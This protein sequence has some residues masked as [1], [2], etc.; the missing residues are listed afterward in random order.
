MFSQS[1]IIGIGGI[2]RAGK[3]FLAKKMADFYTKSGV[4][5]NILDQDNFVFP[6]EEI[7]RING[8]IDWECPESI[9]FPLLYNLIHKSRKSNDVTIVEGILVFW[10]INLINLFDYKI[11]MTLPKDEFIKRKREDLRW[12]KEPEWY[13][14]YIWKMHQ[15]FGQLP[16]AN[17][18]DQI[19]DGR[20]VFNFDEILKTLNHSLITV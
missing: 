4:K 3:S 20:E 1:K 12:G 18:A 19:L 6:K 13:I 10:N 8:H 16:K 9:D 2:S 7:P 15:K 14:E 11:F 17:P 5:V